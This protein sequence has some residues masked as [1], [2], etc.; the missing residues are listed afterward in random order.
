M[1]VAEGAV[2]LTAPLVFE[3]NAGQAHPD[4]V[5]LARGSGGAAGLTSDGMVLRAPNGRVVRVVFEGVH[6]QAAF[7]AQQPTG[8]VSHQVELST[9]RQWRGLSHHAQVRRTALWPGVDV[10]FHGTPNAL[11]YDL[12][13]SAHAPRTITVRFDGADR[14]EATPQGALRIHV[15]DAVLVQ[16]APRAWAVQRRSNAQPVPARFDALGNNRARLRLVAPSNVPVVVDPVLVWATLAGGTQSD[17]VTGVAVA[18]NGD[19]LVAGHTASPDFS[20][21]LSPLPAVTGTDGFILR[22]T[23]DGRTLLQATWLTGTGDQLVNAMAMSDLGEPYVVGQDGSRDVMGDA[24]LYLC[25]NNCA[26]GRSHLLAPAGVAPCASAP[27]VPGPLSGCGGTALDTFRG[28]VVDATGTAYVAGHTD[29]MDVSVRGTALS[30]PGGGR[31]YLVAAF[32]PDAQ[33]LWQRYVGGSGLQ[34]AYAVAL[35]DT[36]TVLVAGTTVGPRTGTTEVPSPNFNLLRLNANGTLPSGVFTVSFGGLQ[37]DEA[38]TLLVANNRAYVGGFARGALLDGTVTGAP[39]GLADLVVCAVD[40]TMDLDVTACRVHGGPTHD[41][42]RVLALDD[43]MRLLVGGQD[44][45]LDP[46]GDGVVLRWNLVDLTDAAAAPL[47]VGDL[48]SSEMVLALGLT[49]PDVVNGQDLIA[50]GSAGSGAFPTTADAPRRATTAGDPQDG[51]VLRANLN[52]TPVV[53]LEGS[54]VTVEGLGCFFTLRLNE[55]T[56]RPVTVAATLGYPTNGATAGDFAPGLLVGSTVVPGQ[57]T[58]TLLVPTLDDAVDEPDEETFD[59]TLSAVTTANAT[60][61]AA[62]T[63]TCRIQDNDAP[64]VATLTAGTAVEGA[65]LAFTITLSAPSEQPISLTLSTTTTGTATPGMDFTPVTSTPVSIPATMLSATVNIVTVD[66]GVHEGAERVDAVLAEPSLVSLGTPNAGGTITDNDLPPTFSVADATVAESA[67]IATVILTLAAVSELPAQGTFATTALTAEPADVAVFAGRPFTI[68]AGQTQVA[69]DIPI[70]HD[71]VDEDPETFTVTAT[72]GVDLSGTPQVATVT[73]TDDDP[74]PNVTME[75]GVALEGTPVVFTLRLNG[76]ATELPCTVQLALNNGTAVANTHY[77]PLVSTSA[78]ITAGQRT[79]TVSVNTVNDAVASAPR[80]FGLTLSAPTGCTLG[81]PANALGSIVDNDNG[82]VVWL[83]S[84]RVDEGNFSTT[85][86]AV[87][88]RSWSA[89]DGGF[90]VD[91]ITTTGTGTTADPLTDFVAVTAGNLSI[92]PRVTS[93]ALVSVNGDV[94]PEADEKLRVQLLNAVGATI[95]VTEAF[96]VIVNDDNPQPAA[97]FA[98]FNTN[99][100]EGVTA[101]LVIMLNGPAGVGGATF[102]LAVS[103]TAGVPQDADIT[104]T[105]GAASGALT[106]DADGGVANLLVTIPAGAV[107]ARVLV[108]VQQDALREQAET[109]VLTLG[110]VTGATFTPPAPFTFTLLDDDPIPLVHFSDAQVDVAEGTALPLQLILSNPTGEAGASITLTVTPGV[111]PA[112]PATAGVDYMVGTLTL[113]VPPGQTMLAVPVTILMDL[114]EEPPEVFT[115]AIAGVQQL[116]EG[117]PNTSVVTIRNTNG[118]PPSVGFEAAARVVG[119]AAGLVTI[120]VY[121]SHAWVEP[122]S[123]EVGPDLSAVMGDGGTLPQATLGSDILVNTTRISFAPQVLGG[124]V[125]V[126]IFQDTQREVDETV[127][128]R[129]QNPQVA[130]LGSPVLLALTIQD[131][132]SPRLDGGA[133]PDAARVDAAVA[134]DASVPPDAGLDAGETSDAGGLADAGMALDGAVTAPDAS[135]SSSSGTSSSSGGTGPSGPCN[136]R[137]TTSPTAPVAL[138]LLVLL[139]RRRRAP[140]R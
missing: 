133:Q 55:P 4:V 70:F 111:P 27:P 110:A 53:S 104:W 136:C 82:P 21:V 92:S 112:T 17:V 39:A 11:E 63:G 28:V 71:V 40:L 90:T 65:P 34:E 16:E 88:V 48:T 81:T 130:T 75:E 42:A 25:T 118:T 19:V 101:G 1:A 57:L 33:L 138:L 49:Q 52:R 126:N 140:Q 94:T 69:L 103:G 37:A 20:P 74:S 125:E 51:F 58:A 100:F 10:V 46:D 60:L 114:L 32:D 119:E 131:D 98:T 108:A 43:Q 113:Q 45:V 129:L 106:P 62:I 18:A 105:A 134:L 86:L 61:S 76:P 87:P 6:R 14:V 56:D 121:L 26:Q 109:L 80:T 22:L 5:Y 122:V 47:R 2:P 7:V 68:P 124:T 54:P 13:L 23:G 77:A 83:E 107:A 128:L 120:T 24:F 123:V 93:N 78:T 79:A 30:F 35:E 132:D 59:V 102:P 97:T 89:N 84:G 72:A 115:V 15:G 99:A 73:I 29:S 117:L 64:P 41:V 127:G 8:G 116:S 96:G 66:D 67:G 137:D 135:S 85:N 3:R 91:Y 31:E 36:G 12:E 38:R 44:S 50:A 9:G 95:A 139:A